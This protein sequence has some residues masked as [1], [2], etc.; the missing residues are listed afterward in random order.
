M[1]G[2]ADRT[3]ASLTPVQGKVETKDLPSS[4]EK[5]V[6]ILFL[7]DNSGSMLAEQQSLQAN[8][9]KF[10][11]V[12]ETLEGGAPN[13]HIGVATSNMGQKA[14]DGV[15]TNLVGG[16][17]GSGDNGALRGAPGVVNGNYIIDIQQGA[18]R[19]RNYTG[20]LGDAFAAMAGVGVD[21][22]GIEQH[23]A[24][25]QAALENRTTNSGF[26]R[27]TAKLAVIVIADEDDC[28]LA[29]NNLFQGTT[30][31]LNFR[32]TKTGITCPGV[33]DLGKPGQYANCEPNDQSQYLEPVDKYVDFIRGLKQNPTDDL[34]VAGIVGDDDPFKIQL[35]AMNNPQL[36]PSCTY[37]GNQTAVPALRTRDFLQQ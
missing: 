12:L 26:L 10:M 36:A 37:G 14:T 16:C 28:S 23:L 25:V 5:D 17:V 3:I 18:T 32:C 13:M 19:N 29:H 8:F 4:L 2:C 21:G 27:E 1:A 11:Q 33:S 15:G 9:P 31:E 7:I 20:T 35:D 30:A 22:C 24:A 6:D 34:I